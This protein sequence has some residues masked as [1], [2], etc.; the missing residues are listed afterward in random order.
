[1][2]D[3]AA[4]R[5]SRPASPGLVWRH[6]SGGER[7]PWRAVAATVGACLLV[8]LV[9]WA[10]L[11]GP[12]QVFTG[13]GPSPSSATTTTHAE[14]A[15]RARSRSST[16]RTSSTR[17]Y[18]AGH[19][20]RRQRDRRCRSQLFCLRSACCSSAYLARPSR[21]VS[22]LAARA[23]L[24]R[25]ADR[26]LRHPRGRPPAARRGGDGRRRRGAAAAAARG[27]AA[28]RDRGVLAPVRDAGGGGR[29]CRGTRGRPRR[30][31]RC[32]CSIARTS[33]RRAVNR[34]LELYREARFSEHDLDESHRD[35]RRRGAR[36]R[37]RRRP[38]RAGVQADRD[39]A[40]RGAGCRASAR[41]RWSS[42]AGQVVFTALDFDPQLRDWALMATAGV[43]LL[44][45]ALDAVGVGV[46]S[47]DDP[48]APYVR[49]DA[50]EDSVHHRV[51]SNHLAARDPG[52]A[53][54][55]LLRRAGARPRPGTSHDPELRA[56][57]DGPRDASPPPTSTAT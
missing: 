36:A 44:W 4:G 22:G 43:V 32:A 19:L 3:G 41:S 42:L 1:M 14:A 37:S 48:L 27:R 17:E 26:R 18:G 47:W 51:L 20:G 49:P 8:T 31:S 12:S 57:A 54:R 39:P 40:R 10:A 13:P 9:A 5:I 24:R 11:I 23:A 34:L 53:L 25:A 28:Q 2:G 7:G 15:R 46:A 29:G 38:A 21:G 55:N 33:T 52:P 16:A 45:L 56:L 30:S 6:D 35:R 50:A